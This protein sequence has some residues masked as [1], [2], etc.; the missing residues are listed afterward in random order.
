[1][2]WKKLEKKSTDDKFLTN[3]KYNLK[4]FKICNMDKKK[5]D[6]SEGDRIPIEYEEVSYDSELNTLGNRYQKGIRSSERRYSD[7][8]DPAKKSF[9]S[10]KTRKT[11]LKKRRNWKKGVLILVLASL[12]ISVYFTPLFNDIENI[13]GGPVYP[14]EARFSIQ[15]TFEINTNK[16][17]EYD[18]ELVV[19]QDI[20]RGDI[21]YINNIIWDGDPYTEDRDGRE[22][23]I[24]SKSLSGGETE[25]IEMVYEVE[26]K[27]I[28]WGYRSENIGTIKDIPDEIKEK[29]IGN[30]WQLD[31]DRNNDGENDWMIQPDH[32]QIQKLAEELV[33]GKENIYDKSRAIYDWINNNIE[34]EI[35]EY[36]LPKHAA[37]VL[38][39]RTGD[40]DEQ[41][42]LYISLSRSV[43]I[44]AWIELG[45]LYDRMRD[46]WGGHGWVRQIAVDGDGSI[47]WINIDPVNYQF[48]A[49]GA[50]R[51]TFWVD[52]GTSGNLDDYYHFFSHTS[53]AD[54]SV[55]EDFTNLDIETK[56][57]VVLGNGELI[58]GFTYIA[59]IPSVLISSYIYKVKKDL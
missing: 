39:S 52:N 28:E 4:D 3:Y 38:E 29:Y 27:T 51:V 31:E 34:Y 10:K 46:R 48:F 21:Q 11:R 22:W 54:V 40:C 5:T 53:E 13:W 36:G 43:G 57:Q 50:T 59:L 19:P 15:R 16:D 33:E 56:G 32:P 26:T 1:M 18:M 12:L 9:N 42:Y 2:R 30:Q 8:S 55:R 23:K 6:H 24:W 41:S 20:S 35:G 45:V 7:E 17:V 47:G 44:P 49:R 14:E 37:W 58:P 25:T